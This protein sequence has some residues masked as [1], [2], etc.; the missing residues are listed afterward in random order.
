MCLGL[1]LNWFHGFRIICGSFLTRPANHGWSLAKASAVVM[2]GKPVCAGVVFT[3]GAAGVGFAY[4]D[5]FLARG[6]Q[7]W[8]RGIISDEF[9]EHGIKIETKV[10]DPK[11]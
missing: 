2:H 10:K 7:A 6:H 5:E 4:A 11:I 1:V 8:G 9:L 3:G